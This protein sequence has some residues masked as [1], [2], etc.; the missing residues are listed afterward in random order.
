MEVFS[1]ILPFSFTGEPLLGSSVSSDFFGF[2]G[3]PN[4]LIQ[5]LRLGVADGLS[6]L[7]LHCGSLAFVSSLPDFTSS[8]ENNFS[9]TDDVVLFASAATR[10]LLVSGF[11]PAT[12]PLEEGSSF[13]DTDAPSRTLIGEPPPTLTSAVAFNELIKGFAV[14]LPIA[15]IGSSSS[16]PSS[17]DPSDRRSGSFSSSAKLCCCTIPNPSVFSTV[18]RLSFGFDSSVFTINEF[19][20]SFTL[21]SGLLPAPLLPPGPPLPPSG[22]NSSGLLRF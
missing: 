1:L 7:L 12:V 17:F 8:C 16:P 9:T 15:A 5:A 11:S 13:F 18:P 14:P 2:L 3:A 22:N 19:F 4:A 20:T 6:L 10:S 21:L